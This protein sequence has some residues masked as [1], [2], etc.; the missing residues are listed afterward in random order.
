MKTS[1]KICGVAAAMM[2]AGSAFAAENPY[3]HSTDGKVVKSNYGL[4]WHTGYWT[5]ALAEALG[6]Q[7]DGCACDADILDKAAC[8]APSPAAQPAVQSVAK[9]TLAADTLFA[10]GKA[11]LRD[12]AKAILDDLVSQLAGVQ[13]E[14]FMATGYTDRIG[15]EAFNMKLSSQRAAAV[16][17]Y[18]ES[19]G[20]PAGVIQTEGLGK[21]D[22]V[23]DCPNPSKNGQIKTKAQLVE[24]LAPNRRAVVEVIG[25]RQAN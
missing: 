6:Q 25:T 2:L 20:V 22:P 1:L 19:K 12:D 7:G 14:V 13:I 5:P 9:I 18:L 10:F 8:A 21:A 4:C 3:V 11:T 24:C 15:S 23:V 16:K 17:A